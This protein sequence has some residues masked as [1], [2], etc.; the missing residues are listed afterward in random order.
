M[1]EP[2]EEETKL[3]EM[4][5]VD[6]KKDLIKNPGGTLLPNE[7]LK[8]KVKPK[9]SPKTGPK[10]LFRVQSTLD[11]HGYNLQEA[12]LVTEDFILRCYQTNTRRI[13]II[14]GKAGQIKNEFLTWM[15]NPNVFS[16]IIS[17]EEAP[18]NLGGSGAYCLMLRKNI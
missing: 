12:Y 5:M 4:A 10:K 9:Q 13:L 1:R 18:E 11:L 8:L 17:C 6:V 15:L 2:T 7:P 14:T 3:W 16:V